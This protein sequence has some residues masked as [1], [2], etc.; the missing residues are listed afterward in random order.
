MS[1]LFEGVRVEYLLGSGSM[2]A[3]REASL[4]LERGGRLTL[5]GASGSGKSSLLLAGIGSLYRNARISGRVLLDGED[6]LSLPR[7]RVLGLR[8]RRISLLPQGVG[9]AFN[10]MVPVGRAFEEVLRFKVEVWRREGVREI[11]LSTLRRLGLE[12][13]AL[14]RY[15][16]QLSGGQRQRVYMA[17]VLSSGAPYLLMDEPTSGLDPLV[18]ALAL[19]LI[20]E[21]QREEGFGLMV[22]THDV[23]VASAL[24]GD[25]GVMAGGLILEAGPS[26]EV[27][28][29]PLH[30]YTRALLSSSSLEGDSPELVESS[31]CPAAGL[32]EDASRACLEGIPPERIVSGRRV[33]CHGL[34]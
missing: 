33:R 23:G 21:R 31:G 5:L 26:A 28:R 17:M 24:G 29:E 20:L 34:P 8:W 16:H 15:P 32:C 13:E 4:E 25:V 12:E 1:L 7:G 9:S 2:E 11:F 18:G 10:P 6:L 22:V 30:P 14:L 3:V 27:L 19:R